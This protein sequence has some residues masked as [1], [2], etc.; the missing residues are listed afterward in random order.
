MGSVALLEAPVVALSAAT[1][2]L[3]LASSCLRF[4]TV[5]SGQVAPQ[6]NPMQRVGECINQRIYIYI[7]I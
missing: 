7:S 4:V 1:T 3:I 2:C 5:E 6:V